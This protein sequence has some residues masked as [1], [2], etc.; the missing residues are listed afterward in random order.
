MNKAAI[1][2]KAHTLAI[3]HQNTLEAALITVHN[4]AIEAAAEWCDGYYEA[5]IGRAIRR[6]RIGGEDMVKPVSNTSTSE[7]GE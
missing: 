5:E 6:L 4:E 1:R 2:A 7:T 3:G